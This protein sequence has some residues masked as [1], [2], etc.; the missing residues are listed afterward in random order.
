MRKFVCFSV[1]LLFE[2]F[3][4]VVCVMLYGMFLNFVFLYVVKCIEIGF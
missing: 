4:V 2:E 1:I 3:I